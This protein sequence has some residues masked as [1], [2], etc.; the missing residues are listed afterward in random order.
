MKKP[1]IIN[2]KALA[3]V[4]QYPDEFSIDNKKNVFFCDLC[5]CDV[6]SDRKST[7][8]SHRTTIK[9]GTSLS[10]LLSVKNKRDVIEDI[11]TLKQND[12]KD[13]LLRAF[14]L[15]IYL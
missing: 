3:Y 5:K 14:Y 15:L 2:I 10:I 12:F 4:K 7:V 8:D 9:H 6:K 11:M 1:G 13:K